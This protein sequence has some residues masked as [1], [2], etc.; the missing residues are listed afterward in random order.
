MVRLLAEHPD[1]FDAYRDAAVRRAMEQAAPS[2]GPARPS[3]KQRREATRAERIR[4]IA[5]R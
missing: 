3:F 1:V 5:Q 4:R 2:A